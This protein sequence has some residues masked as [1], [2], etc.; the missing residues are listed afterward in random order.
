MIGDS[1]FD[2]EFD[3]DSDSDSDRPQR[4]GER[5]FYDTEH[6]YVQW[7]TVSQVPAIAQLHP[8]RSEGLFN[9]LSYD[10]NDKDQRAWHH[11]KRRSR[12]SDG[13]R[14]PRAQ[15]DERDDEATG[16]S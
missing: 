6:E 8:T 11:G 7:H 5:R 15:K 12:I 10:V 1:D 16:C 14:K 4:V 3:F 9:R 2:F 13:R